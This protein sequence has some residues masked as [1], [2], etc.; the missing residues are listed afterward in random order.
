MLEPDPAN[1]VHLLDCLLRFFGEHGEHWTRGTYD[2]GTGNR[3]LAGAVEYVEC[4]HRSIGSGMTDYIVAAIWPGRERDYSIARVAT[5]NDRCK[6]FEQIGAVI[7]KARALAQRDAERLPE[8]IAAAK[9]LA[10]EK[11]Q[12]AAAHKRQL[13]AE[14]ERERMMRHAT[15][16]T[17]ETYILCPRAPEPLGPERLAA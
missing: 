15:G 5:F 16:D 6:G 12:A 13:L 17:R 8:I 11:E 2:D 7:A 10:A 14:L 1:C 4:K 3:C 9:A